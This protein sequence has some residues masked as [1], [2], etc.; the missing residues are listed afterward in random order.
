MRSNPVLRFI[1]EH[2]LCSAQVTHHQPY[3]LHMSVSKE[4]AVASHFANL[5]VK[6]FLHSPVFFTLHA[7]KRKL[8]LNISGSTML[9]RNIL[10]KLRSI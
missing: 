3:Q 1:Y 10:D 5:H 6:Y 4:D 9:A 8:H 2:S 7:G